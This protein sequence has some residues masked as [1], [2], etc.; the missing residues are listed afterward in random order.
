MKIS[1]V[2]SYSVS[3]HNSKSR[4]FKGLWGKSSQA[5]YLDPLMCIPKDIGERYY[6]PFVDEDPEEV[7]AIIEAR[8]YAKVVGGTSGVIHDCRL[9]KRLPFNQQQYEAYM[10]IPKEKSNSDI[11][12][13]IHFYVRDKYIDDTFGSNQVPA[14]NPVVTNNTYSY[15]FMA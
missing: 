8:K 1:S 5:C 2:S 10:K 12:K 13:K 11:V 4:N 3:L 14:Y 9:C 15:A 7:K 6:Y